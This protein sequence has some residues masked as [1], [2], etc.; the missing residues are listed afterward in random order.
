[1]LKA[2][3]KYW[4]I[5]IAFASIFDCLRVKYALIRIQVMHTSIIH[6]KMF[7][8]FHRLFCFIVHSNPFKEG[9]RNTQNVNEFLDRHDA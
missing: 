2:L 1:M 5:P 7:N 6:A 4:L 3:F 8:L 9:E